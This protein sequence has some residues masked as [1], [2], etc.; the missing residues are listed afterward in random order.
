MRKQMLLS[1]LV[2]A[3]LAIAL[4][5]CGGDDD[6]NNNN[7]WVDITPTNTDWDI[8]IIHNQGAG[9][10]ASYVANYFWL[11]N[12]LSLSATDTFS[13][14]I[15]GQNYEV[16]GY[17]MFGIWMIWSQFTL[18]PGQVY[19][20]EFYHN[21]NKKCD[22]DIRMPYPAIASF[23]STYNPAQSATFTWS[24]SNNNQY[25]FAGV[26]AF[27]EQE[28]GDDLYDDAIELL[29][30]TARS[31]TVPAN[32]VESFGSGTEY[33]LVVSQLNF[34]RDGRTAVSAYQG[35]SEDYHRKGSP[36]DMFARAQKARRIIRK[37]LAM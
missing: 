23:P 8:N 1:V 26:T 4:T 3:L 22:V 31:H 29:P 37:M 12:P 25:Q 21:G 10:E 35:Q 11:G 5:G 19:N 20:F 28:V 27:K 13:A 16:N 6:N 15:D 9:K 30:V 34:K 32:A 17:W 36:E 24:L 18:N 2:L 7:N 33:E 14:K